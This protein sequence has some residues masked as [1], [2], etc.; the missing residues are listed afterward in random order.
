METKQK[1]PL[2]V[3]ISYLPDQALRKRTQGIMDSLRGAHNRVVKPV[4]KSKVTMLPPTDAAQGTACVRRFV[5]RVAEGGVG[6][7][8]PHSCFYRLRHS[9]VIREK[10]TFLG[11]HTLYN[12]LDQNV[13]QEI[14]KE[15]FASLG[16]RVAS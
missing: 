2:A 12:A 9:G 1:I 16:G 6:G 11:L 3:A 7:D 10:L 13:M 8:M 14:N 5:G 15:R 4:I